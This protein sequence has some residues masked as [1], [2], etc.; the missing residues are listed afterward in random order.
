LVVDIVGWRA[1]GR[2]GGGGSP[3][4]A[5]AAAELVNA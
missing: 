1:R 4:A 2:P 5:R 3:D